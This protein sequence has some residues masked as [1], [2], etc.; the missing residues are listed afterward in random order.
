MKLNYSTSIILAAISSILA[1]SVSAQTTTVTIEAFTSRGETTGTCLANP[2]TGGWTLKTCNKADPLQKFSFD[3][4]TGQSQGATISQK[5]ASGVKCLAVLYTSSNPIQ[6]N[7]IVA[8]G[9]CTGSGSSVKWLLSNKQFVLTDAPQSNIKFCLTANASSGNSIRVG[10]CSQLA[11]LTN[12]VIKP[13][14]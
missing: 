3:S 8:K 7:N 4:K 5:T 1:Q 12:W 9:N 13:N 2:D 11:T 14:P 10:D 6:V